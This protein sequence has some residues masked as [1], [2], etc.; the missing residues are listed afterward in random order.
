MERITAAVASHPPSLPRS[1]SFVPT[2]RGWNRWGFIVMMGSAFDRPVDDS[3][4]DFGVTP[5]TNNSRT[6]SVSHHAH[7]LTCLH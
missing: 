1:R 3:L 6:A 2:W 7:T 4:V 5:P